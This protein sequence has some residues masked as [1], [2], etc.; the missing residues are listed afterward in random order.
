MPSMDEVGLRASGTARWRRNAERTRTRVCCR[1]L[2]GK[3]P[4]A[5]LAMKDKPLRIARADCWKVSRVQKSPL[6]RCFKSRPP[7]SAGCAGSPPAADHGCKER[8]T[9][10]RR[11]P[12]EGCSGLSPLA[13]GGPLVPLPT[14]RHTTT[15][16]CDLGEAEHRPFCVG[17]KLNFGNPTMFDDFFRRSSPSRRNRAPMPARCSGAF[18]APCRRGRKI[19]GA[20][21]DQ[22]SPRFP[23]TPCTKQ[24]AAAFWAQ[25]P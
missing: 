17:R 22:A 19:L 14:D 3:F 21:A 10:K 13:A 12:G 8:E 24:P 18:A 23:E 2:D 6:R 20:A 5:R 1:G 4:S 9:L 7:L 16:T 25:F 15:G 11:I